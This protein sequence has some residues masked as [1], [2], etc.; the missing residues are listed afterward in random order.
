MENYQ[1]LQNN[2]AEIATPRNVLAALRFSNT[3]LKANLIL[4]LVN[5]HRTEQNNWKCTS[6]HFLTEIC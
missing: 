4:H 1:E 5:I 6:N 3:V 2:F